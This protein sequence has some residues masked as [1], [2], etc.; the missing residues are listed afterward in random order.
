MLDFATG[1]LWWWGLKSRRRVPDLDIS[2]RRHQD[3]EK[4]NPL[5]GGS[6]KTNP[7]GN[8]VVTYHKSWSSENK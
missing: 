4:S 1:W 6:A 5:G 3:V 8:L 7:D 2:L